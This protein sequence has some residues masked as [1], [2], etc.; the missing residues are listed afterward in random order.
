MVFTWVKTLQI[1]IEEPRE[2]SEEKDFENYIDKAVN[3]ILEECREKGVIN[4]YYVFKQFGFDIA[5]FI[6]RGNSV[7]VKFLELKFF[8]GNRNYGVGFG[9]KKSESHQVDVLLTDDATRFFNN[10][11]R[12]VV[13]DALAENKKRYIFVDNITARK[14]VMKDVRKGKQNNFNINKLRRHAITWEEL[15]KKLQEF[16][17]E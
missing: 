11:L 1:R 16:L 13:Y 17:L 9:N 14:C 8:K 15:I 12:W 6:N 10:F 4:N 7:S 2:V 5:V 3:I